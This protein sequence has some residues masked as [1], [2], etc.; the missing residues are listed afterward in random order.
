MSETLG[1]WTRQS[2]K[3]TRRGGLTPVRSFQVTS[4]FGLN[5]PGPPEGGSVMGTGGAGGLGV[6]AHPRRAAARATTV[7]SLGIGGL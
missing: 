6:V 1:P 7:R 4:P 5:S 2:S 3:A